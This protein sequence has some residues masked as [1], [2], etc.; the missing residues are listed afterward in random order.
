MVDLEVAQNLT[1]VLMDNILND[2]GT[3]IEE[4]MGGR[5]KLPGFYPPL[6][7]K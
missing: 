5:T 2:L 7:G 4:G 6:T 1:H 3:M